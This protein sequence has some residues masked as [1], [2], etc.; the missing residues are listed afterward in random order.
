MARTALLLSAL[1]FALVA[2]AHL[3]R[4]AMG[5]EII[6]AG[7]SISQDISLYAGI[8]TA[9]LAAFMFLARR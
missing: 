5:F 6:V 8:G 3:I 4:Y 2:A 1:I 9:V 7:N